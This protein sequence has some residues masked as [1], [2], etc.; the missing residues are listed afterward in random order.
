MPDEEGTQVTLGN[1]MRQSQLWYDHKTD[2][3]RVHDPELDT[4]RAILEGVVRDSDGAAIRPYWALLLMT[5]CD[6]F[7]LPRDTREAVILRTAA[8][9]LSERKL[10]RQ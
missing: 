3:Y 4:A 1:R 6:L 10:R 8:T 2:T 9:T 5:L 7:E